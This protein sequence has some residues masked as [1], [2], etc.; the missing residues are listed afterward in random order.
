MSMFKDRVLLFLECINIAMRE[1]QQELKKIREEKEIQTTLLE[2]AM[3]SE[4][5]EAAPAPKKITWQEAVE[6]LRDLC[7]S[8]PVG[9]CNTAR[10]PMWP[11]CER[12][13][14]RGGAPDGWEVPADE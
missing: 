2:R 3:R 1:T 14:R 4:T 12:Y 7:G 11:F 13:L 5:K 10:C 9:D 8:K 6:T